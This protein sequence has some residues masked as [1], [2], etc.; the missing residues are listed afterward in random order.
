MYNLP[1]LIHIPSFA[2]LTTWRLPSGDFEILCWQANRSLHA[3][4]LRLGSLD[5][6][7]ADLLERRDLFGGESDADLVDLWLVELRRLLWVLE[8]H[9]GVRYWRSVELA[10]VVAK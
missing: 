8:R 3:Q 7:A 6:L 2:A 4:L 1:H 5:K 10:W 9:V